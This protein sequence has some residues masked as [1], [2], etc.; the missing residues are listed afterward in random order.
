MPAQKCE[1]DKA[2]TGQQQG[3]EQ[4]DEDLKAKK[5]PKWQVRDKLSATT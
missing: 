2:G 3:T 1:L 4:R 5:K